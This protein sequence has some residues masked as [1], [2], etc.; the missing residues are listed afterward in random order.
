MIVLSIETSC[1]E[2]AMALIETSHCHHLRQSPAK[3]GD[4]KQSKKEVKKQSLS[5]ANF[6]ILAEAIASQIE[7]HRPYGGVVPTLAK[8]EHIKNLPK[9]FRHLERSVAKSKDFTNVDNK[10]NVGTIAVTVGPGLEPALWTGIN[11]ANDLGKKLNI[12]VIGINHLEGHLF[13]NWIN[14]IRENQKLKVKSQKIGIS[15]SETNIKFPAIVLLVSGGHTILLKMDTINKWSKLGET[16]DDAVGEAFDKVAKML[17][18]PYPGGP[19]IERL[20]QQSQTPNLIPFP[21]PML[22]SKNYD[23]SFSGLKT[24]VLYFL[25]NAQKEIKNQKNTSLH[26]KLKVEIATSFQ[27]AAIDVLVKKTMRAVDEFNAKSILLCGGV[28]CNKALSERFDSEIRNLQL[29]TA[30]SGVPP[31]NSL[32]KESREIQF[33]VPPA[34]YNTDNATMIA[35]AACLGN[36]YPTNKAKADLGL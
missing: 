10:L 30:E 29:T 24:A 35:T 18:L 21:R 33:Y 4:E 19:E 12:P 27:Q 17:E 3:S 11:F 6:K 8:R 1:D 9:L 32:K 7:T 5:K 34:K 23:F 36:H 22:H 25:R 26:N 15:Q 20:A 14:L 13:S 2:T 31:I 16:R 28:A